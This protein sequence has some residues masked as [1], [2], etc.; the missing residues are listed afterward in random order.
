MSQWYIDNTSEW[1]LDYPP[2]FAY[3]EYLLSHIARFFD[4]EML[5]VN[6]LNYASD[7]TV[8]FQRL[9]VIATD[10]V[11]AFGAKR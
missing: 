11:Y 1:T 10:I 8:I 5:Q 3:F 7:M 2:M 4:A 9:S 6:H